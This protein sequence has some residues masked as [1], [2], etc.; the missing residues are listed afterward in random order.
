[1]TDELRLTVAGYH[2]RI[3][4]LVT[5]ATDELPVP[6]CGTATEPQQCVVFANSATETLAWGAEASVHWQ[7]G[8]FLLVDLS[9][10]YVTLRHVLDEVRDAKPAHIVSGRMM[11]P[12]GTGE[13]RLATQATYQSARN[14]ESDG[15]QIGEAL[16]I[17]LGVSGE[18]SRFRYFA[19]VQNL[20]DEQYAL[21]VNSETSA[22]PVPQYGRTFTLQLTGSY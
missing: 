3:S 2:N 7:P 12:L 17:S 5:L 13:V 16:L 15:P 1:L 6:R 11:M 10:S 21:P 4:N 8:R 19:G 20:L 18:Y 14:G 9:Y 22:L